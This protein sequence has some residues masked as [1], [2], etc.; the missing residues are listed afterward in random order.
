MKVLLID[1]VDECIVHNLSIETKKSVARIMEFWRAQEAARGH[2]I[3]R[4]LVRGGTMEIMDRNDVI[5][6]PVG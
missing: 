1:P 2:E 5:P 6:V 4:V 3:E